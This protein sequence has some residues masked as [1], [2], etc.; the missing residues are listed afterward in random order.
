MILFFLNI[1]PPETLAI[2]SVSLIIV[3]ILFPHLGTAPNH[4]QL[5]KML[6]KIP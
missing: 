1:I 4:E 2:G 3:L 5:V 6:S